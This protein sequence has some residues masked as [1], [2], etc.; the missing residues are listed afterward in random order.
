MKR[1]DENTVELKFNAKFYLRSC[2]LDAVKD[3]GEICS[4]E[5]DDGDRY[6]LVVLRVKGNLNVEELGHEFSNYVLGVMK[7]KGEV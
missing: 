3:F 5:V 2:I 7:N 6:I 4:C 1:L